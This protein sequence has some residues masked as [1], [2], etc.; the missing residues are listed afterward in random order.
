[1]SSDIK[2]S[3][4]RVNLL[5]VEDEPRYLESTRRLLALHFQRLDTEMTGAQAL[6][7]LAQRRY[8]LA[9]LD[10]R[11]PDTSDHDLMVHLRE[12]HPGTHIIVMSGD[13]QIESAILC[14][15]R[16]ANHYLRK[17]CEPEELIKTVRNAAQKVRLV[18]DNQ[19]MLQ[20]LEQSEH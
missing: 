8:D 5:I 13:N 10:L 4:D 18:R 20:Q 7:W 16:G 15:R 17:P 19:S 14:I 9:L 2:V 6:N 11:L 1:M 12:R 3:S